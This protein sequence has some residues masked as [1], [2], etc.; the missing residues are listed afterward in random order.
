M[1]KKALVG[2]VLLPFMI[3]PAMAQSSQHHYQGGPKTEVPHHI[4]DQP[5][6]PDDTRKG[7]AKVKQGSSKERHYQGGPKAIH[8]I[9]DF[10]K[11]T[12][13][14]PKRRGKAKQKKSSQG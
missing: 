13:D 11:A 6:S 5:K 14:A 4:G 1:F 12:E 2:A 8:H 3:M 7:R 9:G 10:S